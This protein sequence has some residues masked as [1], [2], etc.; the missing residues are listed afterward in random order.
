MSRGYEASAVV[1]DVPH[2]NAAAT[3]LDLSAQ[4]VETPLQSV[5][6]RV[7]SLPVSALPRT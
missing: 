4:V 1:I 3:D 5:P 2:V 6:L 7:P